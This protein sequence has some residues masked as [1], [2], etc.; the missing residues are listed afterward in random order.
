MNILMKI[1]EG[2]VWVTLGLVGLAI[3]WGLSSDSMSDEYRKEL[4]EIERKNRK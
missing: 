4:D 1:L 3:G 2:V